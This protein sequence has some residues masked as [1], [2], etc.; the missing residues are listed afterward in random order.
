[1]AAAQ[2]AAN[3]FAKKA[4]KAAEKA[5]KHAEEAAR[6]AEGVEGEPQ[7]VSAAHCDVVD[8][9]APAPD[10]S[11]SGKRDRRAPKRLSSSDM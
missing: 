5:K 10:G 6:E 9:T 2:D 4:A 7:L 3:S 11:P 1:M 8:P